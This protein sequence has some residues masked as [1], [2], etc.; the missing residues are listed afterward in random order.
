[1]I[2][3]LSLFSG[4]GAFESALNRGGY[5]YNLVNYCEIDKYASKA[6]S[7]I[8]R[9]NEDLNLWDIQK[10]DENTLKNKGINFIT[11]GFPCTDISMAGQQKGFYDSDGSKTRSGLFFDALRIIKAVKPVVCIAENVKA[12]TSKKF[13]KEFD[14]V[15][16]SLELAGYN[17]H[18]AVLNAKDYGIPQNRE[19][20]FIISIRKDI[21]LCFFE[22][23]EKQKL[24]LRLKDFLE[25]AV[26]EKYFCKGERALALEKELAE[27][28]KQQYS[29]QPIVVASTQKHAMNNNTGCS[30]CLTCRM[31][32]SGGN[33]PMIIDDTQGFENEP[34]IYDDVVP[35]LRSQREGLKVFEPQVL[36]YERTEYAKTIRNKYENGEIDE[37]RCNMR[38]FAL[39]TD[40]VSNTLTTV[41]KDNLVFEPK[42]IQVANIDQNVRKR[43]NP[44][45]GRVYSVDG[46]APILTTMQGGG[47]Q[48]KIVE[49]CIK[50]VGHLGVGGQKGRFFSING[51]APCLTATD[52]KDPVKIVD[53]FN[54]NVDENAFCI[55]AHYRSVAPQ[56]FFDST[57]GHRAT[58]VIHGGRIRKL[59]PREC[60][61][62]M[63]FTDE[64]FDRASVGISNSQL[65][66]MAGNSIVVNVLETILKKLF[67]QVRM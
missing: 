21:D 18:V 13:R 62:L 8:H 55:T 23:P 31:G 16:R 47:S 3:L 53:G 36:K 12:L 10:V 64:E 39:R 67:E 30:P 42:V 57:S 9:V 28:Y 2:R 33:T 22:F 66:K 63:G 59:T 4:I 27:K 17:N 52:Y 61:R 20:V 1:M 60:F 19:R 50:Q 34:R 46:L 56:N 37:R 44:Q 29:E 65:Y 14:I 54:T 6:Y 24:T 58:G 43:D 5:E 35:T 11:Y 38:E 48:P 51:I 32:E 40:G 25:S 41:Q 26:D 7:Q 49:P 45:T 15:L